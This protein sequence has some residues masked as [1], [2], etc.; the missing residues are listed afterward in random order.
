MNI[1]LVILAAL[2]ALALA[3]CGRPQY[4]VENQMNGG[5]NVKTL[6]APAG[7]SSDKGALYDMSVRIC[8]V[9]ANGAESNCQ[10]TLVLTNVQ[11]GSIY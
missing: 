6:L 4:L 11:P 10:T 1:K 8:D 5:R 2:T 3:A 7:A 9:D